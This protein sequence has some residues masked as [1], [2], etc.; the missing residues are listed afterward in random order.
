MRKISKLITLK[1]ISL[2]L[3]SYVILYFAYH[4][5]TFPDVYVLLKKNPNSTN[6]IEQRME[7]YEDTGKKV[8]KQQ[9]WVSYNKI[10]PNIKRAIISSEDGRFLIHNGIDY[11][12][13]YEVLK[14]SIRKRRLIRG[15]STITMQLAK[16]LYL[17]PEK[18]ITRKIKEMI[19]ATSIENNLP[20]WRIFEIYLNI[21]ELGKGIFGVESACKYYFGKSSRYVSKWQAASISA[22]MPF[23][24]KYSPHSK[25]NVI[26]RRR[27]RILKWM[28]GVYYP[29]K[30]RISFNIPV[31]DDILKLLKIDV[32]L[33]SIYFN[34]SFMLKHVLQIN[35]ENQSYI[36]ESN[37]AFR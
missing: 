11:T 30:K 10:S 4:I 26:R 12:A 18:T 29:R 2:V 22:I 9:K 3:L 13:L 8:K 6:L 35:C 20:K 23:P 33:Y 7:H 24:L 37:I 17:S 15:A 14:A 1:N 19:I 5:A 16:N 28:K 34:T 32:V 27:N 31:V 25:S 36:P 21:I